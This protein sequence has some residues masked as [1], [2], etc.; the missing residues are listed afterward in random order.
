MKVGDQVNQHF[1]EDAISLFENLRPRR[2]LVILD[3]AWAFEKLLWKIDSPKTAPGYAKRTI[4]I[5]PR[6]PNDHKFDSYPFSLQLIANLL[7]R[8]VARKEHETLVYDDFKKIQ[9]VISFVKLF[10]NITS[11]PDHFRSRLPINEFHALEFHQEDEDSLDGN[12]LPPII[13]EI[14]QQIQIC[15][16]EMGPPLESPLVTGKSTFVKLASLV[17]T[18]VDGQALLYMDRVIN[19]GRKAEWVKWF[20][21]ILSPPMP[22]NKGLDS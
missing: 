7:Y 18:L 14:F 13:R 1:F 17:N 8:A 21:S 22:S 11:I 20:D 9:V 12:K 19:Y 10:S 2:N 16:E 5:Y 4:C 15:L 6:V 3:D